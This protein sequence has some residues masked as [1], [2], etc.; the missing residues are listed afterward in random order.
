[1]WAQVA[2]FV[3]DGDNKVDRWSVLG[4]SIVAAVTGIGG[5][6]AGGWLQGKTQTRDWVREKRYDAYAELMT[7]FG[8]A[9]AAAAVAQSAYIALGPN[10]PALTEHVRNA[11]D[12][13][14]QFGLAVDRLRLVASSDVRRAARPLEDA[15]EQLRKLPP[16]S[17]TTAPAS[18][19]PAWVANAET[20]STELAARAQGFMSVA[21]PEIGG[22]GGGVDEV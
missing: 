2:A 10:D 8:R 7:H 22:E 6:L 14:D 3:Q 11:W 21:A 17:G 5:V 13:R 19:K 1:V 4:P 9:M 16:M 15:V 12:E 18:H 20:I